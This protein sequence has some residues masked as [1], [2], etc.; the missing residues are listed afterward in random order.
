M[1]DIKGYLSGSVVSICLALLIVSCEKFPHDF[2]I[3]DYVGEYEFQVREQWF[4]SLPWQTNTDTL[5]QSM[6]TLSVLKDSVNYVELK[7]GPSSREEVIVR[8][9]ASGEFVEHNWDDYMASFRGGITDTSVSF[10][11]HAGFTYSGYSL[12]VYAPL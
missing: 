12:E 2:P 10:E 4:Y 11:Y 8:V 3:Q 9:D 1:K 5:Y 6:G 7:F